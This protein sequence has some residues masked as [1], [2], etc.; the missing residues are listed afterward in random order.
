MRREHIRDREAVSRLAPADRE[1]FPGKGSFSASRT[2]PV[3]APEPLSSRW[4]GK[5]GATEESGARSGHEKAV[6]VHGHLKLQPA[7]DMAV[8]AVREPFDLL[9]PVAQCVVVHVEFLGGG[10]PVAVVPE[11]ALQGLQETS[12]SLPVVVE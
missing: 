3:R 9:E 4:R 6:R 12:L 2:T 5:A 7:R 8:D 1:A 10:D 11:K